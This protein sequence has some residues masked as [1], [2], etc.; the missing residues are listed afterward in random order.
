MKP[1]K[2]EICRF[3]RTEIIGFE[4]KKIRGRFNQEGDLSVEKQAGDL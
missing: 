2:M 3:Q 4:S 1:G